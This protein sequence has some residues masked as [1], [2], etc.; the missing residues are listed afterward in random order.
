MLS[1]WKKK[2]EKKVEKDRVKTEKNP[3]GLTREEIIAQAKAN[4]AAARAEIGDETLEKIKEAMLKKENSPIEQ[5]RR[6]I[7]A[8]DQEDVRAEIRSWLRE[9]KENK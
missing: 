8:M 9:D 7:Q 2:P 6:K 4:A 1:F 3:E 5:A